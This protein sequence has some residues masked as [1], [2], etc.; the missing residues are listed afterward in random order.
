MENVDFIIPNIH[1]KYVLYTE[2]IDVGD[3]LYEYKKNLYIKINNLNNIDINKN[4]YVSLEHLK[5]EDFDMD[6]YE[7]ISICEVQEFKSYN[8]NV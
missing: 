6:N 8:M 4:Y 5:K 1:F 7:L 3:I 2:D